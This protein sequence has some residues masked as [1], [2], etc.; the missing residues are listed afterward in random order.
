MRGWVMAWLGWR[1]RRCGFQTIYFSYPSV[2][3]T[4]SENAQ[5]LSQFV[6][7]LDTPRIHFLGHSLGGLVILHMLAQHPDPRIGRVVLAGCPC[8][9]NYA[10]AKLARSAWG[11][12]LI[13][14]SVLQSLAQDYP[15]CGDRPEIGVI[16]GCRPVGAGRLIGGVPQPN[17]G[18]VAVDET[19]LPGA[20][21][22]IVLNVCH[23]C[24]LL[25]GAVARQ[26]SAFLRR[27][28]FLHD[29]ETS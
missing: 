26:A 12:G 10:A 7:S 3:A 21:E 2:R 11:R 17:D 25:S 1:L 18:V 15:S 24:M 28:H 29:T 6:A 5:R 9:P 27:G 14:R 4:L 8:R 22:R 23:T 16:A 20:R 19:F 13:G